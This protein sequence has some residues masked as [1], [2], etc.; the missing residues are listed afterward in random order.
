MSRQILHSKQNGCV[1]IVRGSWRASD[2]TIEQNLETRGQDEK[3]TIKRRIASMVSG[4]EDEDKPASNP[5][6]RVT[7]QDVI[8]YPTGMSAI[9]CVFHLTLPSTLAHLVIRHT[10]KMSTDMFKDLKSVCFGCAHPIIYP[11]PS[12]ERLQGSHTRTRSK[13]TRDGGRAA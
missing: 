2:A 5:K 8:L 4:G 13:S 3:A 6:H 9:W 10:H 12:S 7:E 1:S 11:H